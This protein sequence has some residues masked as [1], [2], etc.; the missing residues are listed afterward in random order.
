ML[1]EREGEEG[2]DWRPDRASSHLGLASA[3]T[4]LGEAQTDSRTSCRENSQEWD[5][6]YLY[7]PNKPRRH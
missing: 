2:S 1:V 7:S 6:L 3:N 5:W 4:A